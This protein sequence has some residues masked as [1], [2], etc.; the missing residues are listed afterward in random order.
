MIDRIAE[1]LAAGGSSVETSRNVAHIL[2][3]LNRADL[4][5]ALN[6]NGPAVE[7]GPSTNGRRPHFRLLRAEDLKDLAPQE[8]LAHGVIPKGALVSLVAPPERYKTF[9]GLDLHLSVETGGRWLGFHETTQGECVYVL[10]EGSGGLQRR[11]AAWADYCGK[12]PSGYFVVESV[13]LMDD[14]ATLRFI[15]EVNRVVA[16]PALIT[17]DTLARCMTGGDE[18]STRDMGVLIANADLVRESTG[19]TV[20][21][22]HHT[23]KGGD[24]ERG[25]SALRG[26]CDTMLQVVGDRD[27]LVLRCEKQKDAPHFSDIPIRFLPHLESGVITVRSAVSVSAEE[28]TSKQVEILESLTWAMEPGGLSATKWFAVSEQNERTFYR[29]RKAL[30][31][32]G[33]VFA[34]KVGRGALYTLTDKGNAALTDKVKFT[35]ITTDDS[36]NA[37]CLTADP[38][39]GG[40]RQVAVTA[41]T[42]N[43]KESP[44]ADDLLYAETERGAL[45]P[46]PSA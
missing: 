5:G 45:R 16:N 42:A 28:L 40:P 24:M 6:G 11:V 8:W 19:A 33:F 41:V 18:N 17:F 43:A 13:P 30:H 23:N 3:R 12:T 29:A 34:D 14:L 21:L 39:L 22:V 2:D 7:D 20:L 9:I 38:P 37:N 46:E 35:D 31:D 15:D 10:A 27:E 32:K 1:V 44:S 25:S 36:D 4:I 26:A